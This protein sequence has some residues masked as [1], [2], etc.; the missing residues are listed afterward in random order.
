MIASR[1][2]AASDRRSARAVT[3]T[4]KCV[5]ANQK[6]I[7]ARAKR[8][9]L[10]VPI[11]FRELGDLTWLEGITENV[12]HSGV[13]FQSASALPLNTTLE[14]RLQ[15]TT[16]GKGKRP[17]EIR[18]KGVVVRVKQKDLPDTAAALAVAMRDCRISRRI[19]V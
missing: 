2:M 6:R 13:L 9:G 1:P 12:S 16:P 11:Y 18:G 5:M 8:Y 3:A 10:R 15:V 17:A 19:P 14:L 4:P 7:C